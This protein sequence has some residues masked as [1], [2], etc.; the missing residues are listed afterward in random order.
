MSSAVKKVLI[1]ASI[2]TVVVFLYLYYLPT[3][4]FKPPFK[5]IT[6]TKETEFGVTFSLY[7]AR[8]VLGLEDWREAY[9]GIIKDLNVKYLRLPVY[10]TDIEPAENKYDF[11]D[12]D[13]MIEQ[14][15]SSE[16]NLVLAV[17]RKLPRWPECFTPS[18]AEVLSEQ[19]QQKEILEMLET[20]ISRY[21]EQ[22][23]IEAWQV[24][25][26]PFFELFGVC[27]KTDKNFLDKEINLV[28]SLDNRPVII[29]DSGE[30][31]F[32]FGA[33][34][35]ADIFG[36]TLYRTVWNKLFKDVTY[37]LGPQFYKF[38][39]AVTNIFFPAR[40]FWIME[41]QTEPWA[42]VSLPEYSL[43]EQIKLMNK[44]KFDE[45]ISFAQ[46]TEF[47]RVYLWGAEWWYW[48]RDKGHNEM[49]DA[50]QELFNS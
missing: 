31:G 23:W 15:S 50:A 10:W 18:W 48:L 4:L 6:K 2:L 26:E 44:T 5:E 40:D 13:W 9:L 45:N 25:N 24:E 37:P 21:Q 34:K 1:F 29:T 7:Y 3:T 8:D 39:V 46:A 42:P 35:R 33:A 16:V 36:S 17:G 32:W 22:K 12:Y 30:W 47:R 49:W 19:E 27:P 41:L 38:K 43:N 20:T 28:R 14:A 11:S